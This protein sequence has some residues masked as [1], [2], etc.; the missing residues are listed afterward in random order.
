MSRRYLLLKRYQFPQVAAQSVPEEMSLDVV[1]I[2]LRQAFWKAYRRGYRTGLKRGERHG[3]LQ[4]E[5]VGF[6][7]GLEKGK[8]EGYTAGYDEGLTTGEGEVQTLLSILNQLWLHL[9][10]EGKTY[11][12]QLEDS[13][14]TA[15]ESICTKVVREE[16]KHTATALEILVR[17]TLELLPRAEGLR[18]VV[19][20]RDKPIIERLSDKYPESWYIQTDSTITTGGCVINAGSGEADARVETRLQRCLGEMKASLEDSKAGEAARSHRTL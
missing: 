9:A 5:K 17:E 1:N 20:P 11:W 8:S 14:V 19:N 7:E 13:V 6:G 15:V 10:G 16:L 4:G 12:S 2:H 3:H 18:V